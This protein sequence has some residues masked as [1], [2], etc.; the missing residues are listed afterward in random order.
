ML[1]KISEVNKSTSYRLSLREK[2]NHRQ[3]YIQIDLN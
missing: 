3:N 1:D 2:Q